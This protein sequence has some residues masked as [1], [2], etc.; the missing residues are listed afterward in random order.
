MNNKNDMKD[1]ICWKHS[2]SLRYIPT[3]SLICQVLTLKAPRKILEQTTIYFCFLFFRDNNAWH[4]M[5]IVC[6]ADLISDAVYPV[7]HKFCNMLFALL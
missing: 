7:V 2:V 3:P 5:W 1:N 4:Y 6:Q